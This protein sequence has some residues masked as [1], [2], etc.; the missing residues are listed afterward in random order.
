[1][2]RFRTYWIG[3]AKWW[4][5][6]SLEWWAAHLT[7]LYIGGAIIIMGAKFD[8]LIV[9]KL[10]EI[11][12]LAAGVFGPVAFLWLVLGYVQQGRE[13]KLSSDA[14]RL[15]AEELKASVEQ[16]SIMA[17][18]AT[19]QLQSQQAAFELQVWK[20]EQDISPE[21]EVK[22]FLTLTL[23]DRLVTSCIRI[24]NRGHDVRFVSFLFDKSLGIEK[25][26]F[27]GDLK[28]GFW[29]EDISFEFRAPEEM[30]IGRCFIEYLRADNKTLRDEF[31]IMVAA[32]TGM[33]TIERTA[34]S[35]LS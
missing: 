17:A 21:F 29:T 23:P 8:E 31:S 16:Q 1:M 13:L 5:S 33:L 20:H 22:S 32:E 3:Q 19:R 30:F 4:C 28:N 6:R 25:S 18:A 35:A 7:A 34:P 26:L 2:G 14:L 11:G 12:D 10:N 24:M 15:Q 9:L 27:F